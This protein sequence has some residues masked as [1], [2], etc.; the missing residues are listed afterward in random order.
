MEKYSQYY[1]EDY[2]IELIT[3]EMLKNKS[4]YFTKAEKVSEHILDLIHS[5]NVCLKDIAAL[6]NAL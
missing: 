3:T 4:K 5:K 2:L 6:A 1:S